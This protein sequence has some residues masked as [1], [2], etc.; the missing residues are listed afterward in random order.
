MERAG[1]D[2]TRRQILAVDLDGT[3]IPLPGNKQNRVD[4]VVLANELDRKRDVI[5]VYV[6]GRHFASFESAR[7]EFGLPAP[8]WVIC[9][10]GTSIFAP[11]PHGGFGI[12]QDYR[13][14]LMEVV[15]AMPAIT[16]REHLTSIDGIRPQ[17]DEKQ[18][19]FK[20][21]FYSDAAQL[22]TTAS[23]IQQQLDKVQAPYTIIQS[24]DPFNGVGLFDL[25]PLHCSKAYA[26]T[27][28][29][30]HL[31]QAAEDVVYAGDSGNDV[32]ALTSG[33]RSIVVANAD[34]QLAKRVRNSHQ[35][36]QTENQLYLAR[37]SA[38]SGV[39]EGCRWFRLFEHNFHN[40]RPGAVVINDTATHFKVWAPGHTR[41]QVEVKREPGTSKTSLSKDDQGYFSGWIGDVKTGSQYKFVL[42]ELE[43]CP[44]PASRFQP[45]GVHGY[46]QVVDPNSFVWTDDD[47][48]GIAKR[49]LIIYELHIGAFTREGTFLA[50]IDRLS[51]LVDLGITAIEL[52]PVTQSPGKWNWGYDG[53]YPFAVRNSYGEPDDFKEF[54]DACHALGIAVI[55]DV[56]YNHVG[57]EG[58]YLG[59]YG[60]CFSQ[61]HSTP[62]GDAFNFDEDD[63]KHVRRFIVDNAIYW[64]DEFHLDGL[65]LDAVHFMYDDSDRTILNEILD[66]VSDFRKSVKRELHLIAETNVFDH[67]LLDSASHLSFD[68]IWCDCLMHSI[69]SHASP[70]FQF[71]NR[72]YR[73]QTTSLNRSGTVMS[74]SVKN[75]VERHGMPRMRNPP[76]V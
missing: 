8:Q 52:M 43:T 54:V 64:L 24:V 57:P 22:E 14:A 19:L 76:Q 49:D 4:L 72:Q 2:G 66:A 31:N 45:D 33:F 71:A 61:K 36:R 46:S 13:A 30:R 37:R 73:A 5:L 35:Q 60:N 59:K 27:W 7:E 11:V 47:W 34:R 21:S 67:L 15:S 17:E 12:V 38:T 65:R 69:Y 55:L 62:W 68:A 44:D 70:D 25:V 50:A 29:I 48:S 32:E 9:D 56:V 58:N 51:S 26:L 39:L 1:I 63:S 23:L 53:V 16:L 28:L 6:T 41:V 18:G 75:I 3:L 10:V 40:N 42:D 20:L 74:I